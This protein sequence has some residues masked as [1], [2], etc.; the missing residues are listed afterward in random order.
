MSKSAYYVGAGVGGT[1]GG[2]APMLWGGSSFGLM[3]IVTSTIG[4]VLG[5][6]LVYRFLA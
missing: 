3:A 5:I 1:L 2:F 6:W 4:G